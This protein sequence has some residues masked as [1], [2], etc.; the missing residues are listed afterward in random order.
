MDLQRGHQHVSSFS[1]RQVRTFMHRTGLNNWRSMSSG[2]LFRLT[3]LE[4]SC[5]E[6]LKLYSE[7]KLLHWQL[8]HICLSGFS[9]EMLLLQKLHWAIPEGEEFHHLKWNWKP[10][11]LKKEYLV[12]I[13]LILGLIRII[14]QIIIS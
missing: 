8:G 9:K 4:Q 5:Q 14:F 7:N 6:Y 3:K 13:K 11:M 2:M 10:R 12:T 1:Q